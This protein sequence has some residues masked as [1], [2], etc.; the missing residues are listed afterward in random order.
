[1]LDAADTLGKPIAK[2][3]IRCAGHKAGRKL[4]G[5]EIEVQALA[6]VGNRVFHAPEPI[7]IRYNLFMGRAPHTK[8]ILAMAL[9][10]D[11]MKPVAAA[12]QVGIAL[13]TMYR[14]KLYKEWKNEKKPRS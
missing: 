11:G 1:V 14:S 10:R 3:H 2:P 5:Q 4:A 13:S 6:H 8:V 9:V 12:K 7:S